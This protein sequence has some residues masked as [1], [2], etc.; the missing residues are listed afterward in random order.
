MESQ[1]QLLQHHRSQTPG[2]QHFNIPK[3]RG[4]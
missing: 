4:A 3:R 1:A 2:L